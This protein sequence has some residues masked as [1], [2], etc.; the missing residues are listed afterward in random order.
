VNA[1]PLKNP[2]MLRYIKKIIQ[3][4]LQGQQPQEVTAFEFVPIS[5]SEINVLRVCYYGEVK[6][7]DAVFIMYYKVLEAQKK[8]EE[9]PMMVEQ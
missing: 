2:M 4:K 7:H 3:P 6:K 1:V 5:C 9:S 8:Q